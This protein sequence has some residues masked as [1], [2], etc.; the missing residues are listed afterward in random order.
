MGVGVG[1][2]HIDRG[3]FLG[4][5]G[6]VENGSPSFSPRLSPMFL[7][8]GHYPGLGPTIAETMS[9]RGRNRRVDQNGSQT[10][11]KKQFQLDLDK[12]TSGEDTRTTLMIKNIPN[13]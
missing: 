10:D 1:L 8:N 13:K 4:S 12:I 3:G 11:S 2:G 9:D 5:H 6:C 7:G